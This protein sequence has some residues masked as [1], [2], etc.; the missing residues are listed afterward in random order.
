MRPV[1]RYRRD[2][3]EPRVTLTHGRR[4]ARRLEG[5]VLAVFCFACVVAFL[6]LALGLALLILAVIA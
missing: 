6:A 1:R 2:A 3:D 4:R 5:F